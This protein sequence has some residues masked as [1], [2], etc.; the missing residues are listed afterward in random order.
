MWELLSLLPKKNKLEALDGPARLNSALKQC[1][2]QWQWQSLAH[3]QSHIKTRSVSGHC[4][5]EP[6]QRFQAT[7]LPV[8]SVC[9]NCLRKANSYVMHLEKQNGKLKF[10]DM[11]SWF[12]LRD[13]III[14]KGLKGTK[15]LVS[16]MNKTRSN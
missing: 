4:S 13:W 1:R 11:N 15:W 8:S 5:L 16:L 2:I 14:G 9:H 7:V 10:S 3:V 6:Y 12:L